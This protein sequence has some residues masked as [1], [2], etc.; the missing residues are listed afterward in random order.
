VPEERAVKPQ[1]K[2]PQL[3]YCV[4]TIFWIKKIMALKG[5]S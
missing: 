4:L 1:L 3:S 2:S 5:F